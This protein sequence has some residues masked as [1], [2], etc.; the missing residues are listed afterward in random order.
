MRVSF[1]LE[2]EEE[3]AQHLQDA[4]QRELVLQRNQEPKTA[5]AH[6]QQN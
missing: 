3:K 2:E 1:V 4:L 5:A 6:P